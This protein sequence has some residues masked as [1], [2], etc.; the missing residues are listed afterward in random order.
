MGIIFDNGTPPDPIESATKGVIKASVEISAEKLNE[1]V[2]KFKNKKI[3]FVEDS[4]TI[5]RIQRQKE[6]GEWKIFKD[7]I[8]DNDLRILYRVGLTLR[9]Y[10]DE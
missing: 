5:K 2:K 7:F 4:D 3:A 1:L 9:E 6:K 10:E 8:K